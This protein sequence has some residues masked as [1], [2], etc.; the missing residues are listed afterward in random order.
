M[1]FPALLFLTLLGLVPVSAY[2]Q[3]C[4]FVVSNVNFGNVDTLSGNAIDVTANM[5]VSCTTLVVTNVRVCLN[6]NA[7]SA[8]AVGGVRRMTSPASNALNYNF[9]QDAGHAVPWGSRETPTLGAPVALTFA[10]L[11]GTTAQNVTVYARIAA[12]QQAA[13]PGL[14]QS[15]FSGAQVTFNYVT[16]LILTSPPA[17]S[18]VTQ[19]PNRPSFTVQA[20]I[21]PNCRVT[22]QNI[23]FGN[24]GLLDGNVDADGNLRVTCTTGTSYNVGLGN[25]QTGTGPTA[26][27]MTRGGQAITY[28]LYKNAARS[29]AWGSAGGLLVT[30]SGAGGVQNLPVY[31]RVPPQNTPTPGTYTDTVVVTVTY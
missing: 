6:L 11:L 13:P 20:N 23:N 31:G 28:G 7:G 30:G 4:S 10:Q 12:G 2:A 16:Y 14:Y 22:A 19:N 9:F 27:R 29:Q 8:G 1:R 5:T 26:R 24:H 17:C 25:G 15:A 18:T 21:L 3:T